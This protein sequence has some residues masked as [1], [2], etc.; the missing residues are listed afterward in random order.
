M[1]LGGHGHVHRAQAMRVMSENL[2]EIGNPC[3][4][5][6]GQSL[7]LQGRFDGVNTSAACSVVLADNL[8]FWGEL[9]LLGW[10]L[11]P[12]TRYPQTHTSEI[13]TAALAIIE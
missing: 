6:G 2:L 5:Q 10:A 1:L 8:G 3:I 11:Y 7:D 9:A 12:R 4:R 13:A